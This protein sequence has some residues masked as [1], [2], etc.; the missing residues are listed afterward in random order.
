[1]DGSG[2]A[3]APH[4]C[5][6]DCP[7]H[8]EILDKDP[9]DSFC[10]DD[11]AVVCTRTPNPKQDLSSRHMADHNPHRP[12]AVAIRPYNVRKEAIPPKWCP[13]RA[14]EPVL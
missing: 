12:V 7:Y 5:C 11:R 4:A 13:L 1:L 2:I 14:K 3:A 6:I 8:E 9:D 10:D